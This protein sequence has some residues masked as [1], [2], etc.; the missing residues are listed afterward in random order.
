MLTD[1]CRR[2]HDVFFL[3][4]SFPNTLQSIFSASRVEQSD[5]S[6]CLEIPSRNAASRDDAEFW[7]FFAS[8]NLRRHAGALARGARYGATRREATRR[9]STFHTNSHKESSFFRNYWSPYVTTR[10]VWRWRGASLSK[11]GVGVVVERRRRRRS[12]SSR[13][14]ALGLN[15]LLLSGLAAGA[16]RWCARTA[17]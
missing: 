17:R 12:S 1:V 2:K 13:A 8:R 15:S 16:W 10:R 6:R 14:R 7:I 9:V 11:G 4:A 3:C 5:V